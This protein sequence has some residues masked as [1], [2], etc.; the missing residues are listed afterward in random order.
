MLRA[1][2]GE[3]CDALATEL[4]V[5]ADRI[6]SWKEIFLSGGKA[7]LADSKGRRAH[8]LRKLL[9]RIAPWSALILLLFILVYFLTRFMGSGA[10]GGE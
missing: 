8:G 1:V 5:S 7:A 9:D 10:G 6:E 3:S 2:R 4:H